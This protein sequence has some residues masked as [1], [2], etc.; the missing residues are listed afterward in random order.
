MRVTP[1]ELVRPASEHLASYRDALERDWSPNTTDPHAGRRELER[2]DADPGAFLAE[3]DDRDA[4]GEP[5]RLPDGTLVPRLPGFRRWV[6][7]GG[8]AGIVNVRWRPGTVELPPHVLGHVGYSI[9]PWRQRRGYA[10][11]ALRLFLPELRELALPYVELTTDADNLA[12][13][14]A[15]SSNGGVVVERFDKPAA[16]GGGAALRWRIHV[17]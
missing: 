4:T 8:F 2:L 15:I 14:K 9:V 16:Y 10:T 11:A 1:I 13:Q 3:Q 7:D 5:I 6:W 17:A 12:S